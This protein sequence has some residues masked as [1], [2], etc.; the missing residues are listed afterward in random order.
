MTLVRV[1]L[2]RTH[3]LEWETAAATAHRAG[4]P[5]FGAFARN[6]LASPIFAAGV[7]AAVAAVN[8]PAIPSALPLVGLWAAAPAVA[9]LLSRPARSRREVLSADDRA[10]LTAVAKKTW[11]YFDTFVGPDVHALPPDNVQLMPDLR[12]ANRTSPTN[13]AMGLLATLSAHDLGFITVDDLARRIDATLSTVEGLERFEGHLLNWY[14]TTTLAP[15]HPAYVSTV[16]SGNLAGA[17]VTLAA[18]LPRLASVGP[19]ADDTAAAL[20]ALAA[21]AGALFDAMDFRH[22]YDAR[23]QLFAVGYR[24]ADADGDGR[25]DAARYDLLAS[26]ARLASLLAISKGDV[27][28]SHWFHLGRSVTAVHGAPVLLSWGATLFEYLMPLLVTRTYAGTLLDESCRMAVEHQIDYGAKLGVPWGISESAYSAVDRHDTYQYKAFGVPGLGLK[29]GLGDEL[30][31]APYASA[32]A[33]MLFPARSTGNLRRLAALGLESEYGFF[34]AIDYTDRGQ[35][36]GVGL[37][38]TANPIVV[39]TCMAHH[40]G[41]TLVALAHAL[42]GRSHGRAFPRGLARAGNRTAAAGTACRARCPPW[43]V[44]SPTTCG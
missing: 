11:H 26:E 40:Q 23:R 7:L 15:L 43:R 9:F 33:A 31:V 21:R 24:L 29:R 2:T 35:D 3:L 36:A 25:L 37:A 6:M 44:R 16:D 41:M 32:L 34:D 10:F 14:D 27:P 4:P 18:G 17:L 12:V 8:P 38:D 22:L 1:G 19:I 30:V 20:R 5:R 42:A 13:I 28:E 39:R